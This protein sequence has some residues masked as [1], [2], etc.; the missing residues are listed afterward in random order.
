LILTAT[1]PLDAGANLFLPNTAGTSADYVFGLKNWYGSIIHSM[2]LDLNG[3]TIIQQT[4]YAV[5]GTPLN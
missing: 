3:T 1:S 5:C 4:P 2:T